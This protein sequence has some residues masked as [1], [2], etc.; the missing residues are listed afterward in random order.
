MKNNYK[1]TW[2]FVI[3]GGIIVLYFLFQ[4][5]VPLQFK[6]DYKVVDIAKNTS[7]F[8]LSK[9]LKSKEI[10]RSSFVF[11]WYARISGKAVN[12]QAGS[13][14]LSPSQS[15]YNLLEHLLQPTDSLNL[16]K[17]VIPEG[18]TLKQISK[19]LDKLGVCSQQ[20]FM[21]FLNH[22]ALE[23]FK[24]T[25]P[26]LKD[27]SY[28]SLEG[29]LFPDTYYLS[30]NMPPKRVVS[31]MLSQFNKVIYKDWLHAESVAKSPKKRFSF[32]HVLTI[33]SL[34]EK[35]AFL[36][37]EMPLISAVFYNRLQKR[38]LLESCA[39]VFYALDEGHRRR[40][41][42]K[43]LKV[44]SPFNTYK[45]SGFPPSPISTVGKD[46][47]KAALYPADVNYLFFVV[48]KPGEHSFSEFYNDH[49]KAQG[50]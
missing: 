5:F 34:I 3:G 40:L 11:Y 8:K 17:I 21:A 29:Y 37:K 32:H 14:R 46:A 44:D 16:V 45:Y 2:F 24:N 13:F 30:K 15:V 38:M 36:K 1:R 22:E 43:D 18:F 28:P 49:L 35:E 47:F 27:I 50:Y 10:I 9:L 19:R 26:F 7:V 12:I 4:L 20:A 41:Y 48:T 42:Y 31:V 39:S 33:A 23:Y 6:P 25:Y